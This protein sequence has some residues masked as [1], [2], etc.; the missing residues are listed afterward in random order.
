MILDNAYNRACLQFPMCAW[1]QILSYGGNLCVGVLLVVGMRRRPVVRSLP[2]DSGYGA[3]FVTSR[4]RSWSSSVRQDLL[5]LTE[6]AGEDGRGTVAACTRSVLCSLPSLEAP[7]AQLYIACMHT[8]LPV[9]PRDPNF[10]CCTCE[11]H[12][13]CV[14]GRRHAQLRTCGV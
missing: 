10:V 2:N 7:K 12:T 9:L 6:E 8:G 5:P 1:P 14:D 3:R 4:R 11:R 13:P